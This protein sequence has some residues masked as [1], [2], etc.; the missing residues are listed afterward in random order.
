MMAPAF[1]P[2][3]IPAAASASV[4]AFAS[5]RLSDLYFHPYLFFYLC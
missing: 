2:P 4:M 3:D 5:G 1:R